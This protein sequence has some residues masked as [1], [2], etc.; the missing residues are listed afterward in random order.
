VDT[1]IEVNVWEIYDREKRAMVARYQREG[2]VLTP[3]QYDIE[4]KAI[5]DKYE[6]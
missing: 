3:E 1:G 4:I 2:K 6:I 5:C